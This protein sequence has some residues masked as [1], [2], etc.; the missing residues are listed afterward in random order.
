MVYSIEKQ[1]EGEV[2]H[3]FLRIKL[4]FSLDIVIIFTFN[5]MNFGAIFGKNARK[6]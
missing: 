3:I 1:N 5:W 6:C 2:E 4:V